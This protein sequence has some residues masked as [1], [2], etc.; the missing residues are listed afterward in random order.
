MV[1]IIGSGL[2]GSLLAIRLNQLGIACK[3]FDRVEFGAEIPR[4]GRTIAVTYGSK[5]FLET[6]GLWQQL[7]LSAQPI[8][9]IRVLEYGS[10]WTVDYDAK[11][12]GSN[13]MGY[14]IEFDQ[15]RKSMIDALKKA[16][17]IQIFS[18]ITI[19]KIIQNNSYVSINTVEH[20]EMKGNLLVGADGKNSWVR[21]QV[22]IKSQTKEYGHKALVAHFTHEKSHHDTAWEVFHAKGPFAMLPMLNTE[23]GQ[24]QSGIVWCRPKNTAWENF[25]DED[26]QNNLE[27][28]FPYYGKVK[29]N[30]KLWVFPI[31]G[32]S[33][34]RVFD[35]RVVL[36]GDSAHSLHPIAGQGINLGW[37]DVSILAN[38]LSEAVSLGQ[39][40]GC[41]TFLQNFSR[42]R[43]FDHKSL[44]LFT[45]LVT[46]LFEIDNS[47]VSMV[48]QTGFALVNRIGPL[49]RYFMKRAISGM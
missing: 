15:L 39:D 25:S 5:Q 21:S 40:Y 27:E 36:V 20:G 4:D 10:A 47:L 26:L 34:D 14:I 38:L 35:N 33:V 49:K 42:K 44:F 43:K 22:N 17:S 45:H 2:A 16:E 23:C 41:Q 30:S 8:N 48:R 28:I 11:E 29:I 7:A 6:C 1:L 3:L 9:Q 18:P 19:N 24:Y 31:T 37:R 13:P 46:K 12:L 32:M